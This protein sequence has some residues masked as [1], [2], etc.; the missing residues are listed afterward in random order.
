VLG[1]CCF[2]RFSGLDFGSFFAAEQAALDISLFAALVAFE[3]N[4]RLHLGGESHGFIGTMRPPAVTR[5]GFGEVCC[6]MNRTNA[7]SNCELDD[8]KASWSG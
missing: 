2:G 3:L 1:A 8:D 5:C 4:G 6:S 7:S